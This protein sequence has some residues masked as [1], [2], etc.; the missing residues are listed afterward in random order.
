MREDVVRHDER[1][2]L[3][4]L[5]GELEELLVVVLLGVE[6]DDVE[7]VV[8]PGQLLER[9]AVDQ[10]DPLFEARLLDVA[11]PGLDLRRIVFERKHAA[12][13]IA[14]SRGEPDRRVAARASDLEHLAVSLRRDEREEEPA[15]RRLDL[16]RALPGREPLLPLGGILTLE[17]FEDGADTVVEHWPETIVDRVRAELTIEIA[18]TPSDVFAYLTD[19]SNLPE[20]QEGVMSASLHDG[21]IEESRTLLGQ[22]LETTLEVVEREEPRLFTLRAL[23]GPVRVRIRHELEPA[24]GGTQLTVTAEGD[25]PG[26]FVAGLVARRVEKQF[27]KDFARL[28]QI[29][30]G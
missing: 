23:D 19:A 10:L 25:V 4:L 11:T 2:G 16:A 14:N 26:G 9:I 22:E 12:A 30:E 7:H 20:W 3:E 8:D 5:A 29:L 24:A 15:G 1:A 27:R 18:R 21:L 28:K 6:E 17:P 13:E